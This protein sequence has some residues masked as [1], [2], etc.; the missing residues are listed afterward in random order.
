[1]KLQNSLLR[2]FKVSLFMLSMSLLGTSSAQAINFYSLQ[3]TGSGGGGLSMTGLASGTDLDG[4]GILQTSNS[5][6]QNEF[7]SFD[8][9]FKDNL[10]VI[11]ATY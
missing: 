5:L 6:S 7:V 3:W 11:L 10:S 8:V 4:N 9:T 2:L 1:M